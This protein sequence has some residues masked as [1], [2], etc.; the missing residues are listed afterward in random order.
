[1]MVGESRCWRR[2][3]TFAL[4]WRLNRIQ[5][6]SSTLAEARSCGR[7]RYDQEAGL[8]AVVADSP[9]KRWDSV[10]SCFADCLIKI[11][12]EANDADLV[13]RKSIDFNDLA[14]FCL[15]I[16]SVPQ[17][18]VFARFFVYSPAGRREDVG[19]VY[20]TKATYG[21][22]CYRPCTHSSPVVAGT[23]FLALPSCPLVV[24]YLCRK[25]ASH[26]RS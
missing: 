14:T 10:R 1:M 19:I 5:V 22:P 16:C 23:L 7:A 15:R 13:T 21:W 6:N 8:S 11:P 17:I 20:P 24:F 3:P 4:E 26:S 9:M 18:L 25:I 12:L 2:S